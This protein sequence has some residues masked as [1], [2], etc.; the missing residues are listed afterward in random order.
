MCLNP[1]IYQLGLESGISLQFLN[2]LIEQQI[3][4]AILPVFVGHYLLTWVLAPLL[5]FG[6]I[7]S[8]KSIL[9]RWAAVMNPLVFLAIGLAGLALFP[10]LFRY[11]A[12][13]SI[14]KGNLA[15]FILETVKTWNYRPQY[16]SGE[17]DRKVAN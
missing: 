11:L 13:G 17:V 5:L 9:P 10:Q 7:I 14:N 16:L 6:L 4:G 1:L 15:L 2:A 12:P 3:T 8:G